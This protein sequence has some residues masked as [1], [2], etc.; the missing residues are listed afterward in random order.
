VRCGLPPSEGT[1]APTDRKYID[2][3]VLDEIAGAVVL[4][5]PGG[6]RFRLTPV[7]VFLMRTGEQ[8]FALEIVEP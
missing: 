8:L 2:D 5:S 7:G 6:G 4:A 1:F 3:P